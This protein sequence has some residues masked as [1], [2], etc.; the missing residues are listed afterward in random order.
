VKGGIRDAGGGRVAGAGVAGALSYT[1]KF[2]TE[3]RFRTAVLSTCT[4]AHVWRDASRCEVGQRGLRADV[5]LY[6]LSC[7]TTTH[8]SISELPPPPPA[9]AGR[10][11]T[12]SPGERGV[13]SC[14]AVSR[15]QSSRRMRAATPTADSRREFER[16]ERAGAG[17]DESGTGVGTTD[18]YAIR[19]TTRRT[20]NLR[21]IIVAYRL[22]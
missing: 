11:S 4:C 17:A 21:S 18:C 10:P 12:P 2:N 14:A 13:P 8:R 22:S 19:T 16:M 1:C 6:A 7:N 9:P 20:R 3:G 15:I 5:R